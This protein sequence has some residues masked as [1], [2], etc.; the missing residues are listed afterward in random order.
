MEEIVLT[1]GG[2][3]KSF[4]WSD[5]LLLLIGL[6]LVILLI[7][8]IYLIGR[9]DE[10]NN[11]QTDYKLQNDK[12]DI[13]S[14]IE[15]LEANYEAKPIDLSE[16]EQEM[17]NT[18]II[19]Y[20]ELLEKTSTNITYDDE[21]VSNIKDNDIVVKKVDPTNTSLTKEMVDLPKAIMMN[22]ESEEAFLKALKKLQK[23]L[24]R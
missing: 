7:Y 6:I 4:D 2:L 3:I 9:E 24:V 14:I 23:N 17:E 19:S 8:I 21:Y 16:Y 13:K 15:N 20:D 1:I 12:N 22:Y 18:A 11:K 5:F 10:V